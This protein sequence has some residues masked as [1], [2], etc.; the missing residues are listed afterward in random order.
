MGGASDGSL[1]DG[2]ANIDRAPG[3][4]S[5]WDMHDVYGCDPSHLALVAQRACEAGNDP[6]TYFL[7]GVLAARSME[8]N[9]HPTSHHEARAIRNMPGRGHPSEH[10]TADSYR[11]ALARILDLPQPQV[12]NI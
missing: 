3:S 1:F 11:S 7:A 10:Y 8:P 4:L 6:L 9:V 12:L 5:E 2:M